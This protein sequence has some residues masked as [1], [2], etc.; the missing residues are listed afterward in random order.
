MGRLLV[1]NGRVDPRPNRDRSGP[2][3]KRKKKYLGKISY[4]VDRVQAKK[5]RAAQRGEASKTLQKFK[6]VVGENNPGE[7]W[8]VKK[9]NTT[10]KTGPERHWGFVKRV[11]KPLRGNK[12]HKAEKNKTAGRKKP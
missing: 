5:R 9:K 4:K 1:K 10:K 8:Q 12:K 11:R 6:E 3:W 2:L 7:K